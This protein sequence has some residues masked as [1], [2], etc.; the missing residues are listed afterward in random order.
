L[1]LGTQVLETGNAVAALGPHAQRQ[2][3]VDYQINDDGRTRA[4]I[5]TFTESSKVDHSKVI[6]GFGHAFPTGQTGVTQEL[7]INTRYPEGFHQL[8]E[9]PPISGD[10][11]R[12]GRLVDLGLP[13]AERL[14]K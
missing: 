3:W 1:D 10:P 14:S 7:P 5:R 13:I 4:V 2:W 6:G 11:G 12:H 8:Y 9:G